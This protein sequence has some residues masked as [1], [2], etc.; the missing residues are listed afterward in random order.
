MEKPRTLRDNYGDTGIIQNLDDLDPDV[1]CLEH[2]LPLERNDYN[3]LTHMC[4][5]C[6]E[7]YEPPAPTFDEALSR[8]LGA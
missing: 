3:M 1:Y 5:T 2:G 8:K 6:L 7:N 4:A